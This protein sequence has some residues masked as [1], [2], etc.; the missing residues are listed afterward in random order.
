MNPVAL[1]LSGK[2]MLDHLGER[3]AAAKL[4][5]PVVAVIEEGKVVS[6]DMKPDRNDPTA[7]GIQEMADAICAKMQAE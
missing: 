5:R 4:D 2:M 1:I 7:V 6:Y 3:E